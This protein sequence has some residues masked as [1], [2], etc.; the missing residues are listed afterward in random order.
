[1]VNIPKRF[2]RGLFVGSLARPFQ[3]T[4]VNQSGRNARS[5]ATKAYNNAL[6]ERWEKALANTESLTEINY[7]GNL[8]KIVDPLKDLLLSEAAAFLGKPFDLASYLKNPNNIMRVAKLIVSS[9]NKCH[10]QYSRITNNGRDPSATAPNIRKNEATDHKI[11][12]SDASLKLIIHCLVEGRVCN[13]EEYKLYKK[14][15]NDKPMLR[16]VPEDIHTIITNLEKHTDKGKP[17][18]LSLREK[19]VW[20]NSDPIKKQ[21]LYILVGFLQERYKT[22]NLQK[23][24]ETACDTFTNLIKNTNTIQSTWLD[25]YADNFSDFY[26]GYRLQGVP[27]LRQFVKKQ[28]GGHFDK[29]ERNYYA[30]IVTL[31]G[32]Q[33]DKPDIMDLTKEVGPVVSDEEGYEALVEMVTTLQTL[34]HDIRQIQIEDQIESNAR[35]ESLS[36]QRTNTLMG[37][38]TRKRRR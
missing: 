13:L 15:L 26:K 37:G 12:V 38:K 11:P 33:V 4:F 5:L 3:R 14:S 32:D 6:V 30:F 1:M 23:I 20:Y 19:L 2:Q 7:I 35:S 34:F 9:K 10:G 25:N 22:S 8:E 36:V 27:I 28:R 16:S 18:L 21:L 29:T 24:Q 17:S 31:L